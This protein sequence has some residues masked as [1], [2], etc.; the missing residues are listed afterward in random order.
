MSGGAYDYGYSRLEIYEGRMKDP[1]MEELLKDF[2][3]ILHSLEWCDSGDT[4]ESDYR[5][6]V[7]RFKEKWLSKG[8]KRQKEFV[9][10]QVDKL[11]NELML[12]IG[13]EDK[14]CATCWLGNFREDMSSF[15]H[16]NHEPGTKECK[17]SRKKGE[18]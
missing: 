17:E 14:P 5:A 6:D 15:C 13:A 4:G 10:K 16:W 9:E 2:R 18:K 7:K 8:G 3:E 11:R 1:E 12:M